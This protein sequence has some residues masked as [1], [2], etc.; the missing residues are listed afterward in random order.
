MVTLKNI[1][2]SLKEIYFFAKVHKA[3]EVEP[4]LV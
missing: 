4:G 2:F 3:T 1:G